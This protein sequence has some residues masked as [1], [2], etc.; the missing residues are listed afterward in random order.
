M[1]IKKTT[2]KETKKTPVKKTSAKKVVKKAGPKIVETKKKPICEGSLLWFFTTI[3]FAGAFLGSLYVDLTGSSNEVNPVECPK[4]NDFIADQKAVRTAGKTFVSVKNL[5]EDFLVELGKTKNQDE[6]QFVVYGGKTWIPVPGS[7]IE[8]IA[9]TDLECKACDLQSPIASLRQNSTPALLVRTVEVDS[10]EGKSLVKK[11]DIKSIPQF[12]LADG[13][14]ELVLPDG[15]KFVESAAN[16]LIKKDA[17]YLLDASKVGFKLGQFIEAPTFADLDSEPVQ[18]KGGKV[19]VVEF[20][21]YQCPYCKRLHDNNKEVID[22]LVKAGKIEYIL[23]DFPLAF[24]KEAVSAHKAANCVLREGD[25]EDYWNMNALIFKNSEAWN[26]KGPETANNYFIGLAKDLDV[27]IVDCMA[28]KTLEAEIAA[29]IEEGQ[30]YGVS[31]TP[32]LFIG[33]S[34][35]PGAIDAATFEQAVE[36]ALK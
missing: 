20:T 1:A 27:E 7:P 30:K 21:D 35:M 4:N 33:N 32:A 36:N 26:G 2:T 17:L 23:K 22:K 18:G 25:N 15:K 34:V 14:E 9:L 13:T 29:D 12:I 5:D 8:V 19:R 24:H 3:L 11:F 28:D 6:G 16:V 31:G 10:K